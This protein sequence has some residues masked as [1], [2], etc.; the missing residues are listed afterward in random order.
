MAQRY[1]ASFIETSAKTY[2]NIIRAFEDLVTH[3][4]ISQFNFS[5]I[6]TDSIFFK[7][8][9]QVE[10][11]G[12]TISLVKSEHEERVEKM[13]RKKKCCDLM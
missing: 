3:I 12:R 10:E 2:L 4:C 8:T 5:A 1:N 9:I 13:K 11:R 6:E 7:D